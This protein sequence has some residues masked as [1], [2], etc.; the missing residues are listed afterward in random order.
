MIL[1]HNLVTYTL[2]SGLLILIAGCSEDKL[3][4]D[5]TYIDLT[6]ANVGYNDPYY[7]DID[8]DGE[9]EF[10][11]NTSLIA[12]AVGDHLQFRIFPRF[13]NGVVGAADSVAVLPDG[14][15]IGADAPPDKSN[16]ILAVKVTTHDRISWQGAWHTVQNRYAG[17]RFKLANSD[18]YYG[19]VRISVD[20]GIEKVIVHDMA[21]CH[22]AG[23]RI[24]AGSIQ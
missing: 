15:L 3:R 20:T 24:K 23:S 10:V 18:Y 7:L 22:I 11:L 16:Q 4:S 6:D 2:I 17:I 9:S 12:D 13:S 14:E 21:Y 8:T 19:W 5:I 1:L